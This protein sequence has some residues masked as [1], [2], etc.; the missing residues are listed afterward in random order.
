MISVIIFLVSLLPILLISFF[1]YASGD[2]LGYGAAVKLVLDSHGSVIEIFK[3]VNSTIQGTW[4][5]WQG[6][7]SSIFLFC[8][9]PSI[10][11]E[12]WYTAVPWI[13]LL[14]LCG[15]T[16]YCLHFFLV[17]LCRIRSESFYIIYSFLMIFTIQYM[18]YMRGG[19]FWY[20]SVSH[21]VIPYGAAL[22]CIVWA[23]KYCLKRGKALQYFIPLCLT[24]TYLGGAGYLSIVFALFVI[25]SLQIYFFRQNRIHTALLAVPVTLLLFGFTISAIAPGNSNRGGEGFG[26]HLSD[27]VYTLGKSVLEGSQAVLT[28]FIR[29]RPLFLLI[30][31]LVFAIAEGMDQETLIQI[32][33]ADINSSDLVFPTFQHPILFSVFC[34][35]TSCSVYAP[36]IYANTGVS[37]GVPDTIW[38]VFL[39]LLTIGLSYLVCW[40]RIKRAEKSN[41]TV[42]DIQKLRTVFIAA[43]L[44]FCVLFYRHL[45]G[46]SIDYTCYTFWKS[47]QLE[48]YSVQMKERVDLLA[49]PEKMDVVVPE[50]NEAQGPF[51]CMAIMPDKDAFVNR[52]TARFYGKNSVVSVPRSEFILRQSSSMH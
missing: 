25:I 47:G 17:R 50:M 15:G 12:R 28:S 3:A 31:V 30:P 11:G 18:P 7:W 23:L 8:F 33:E 2:D 29:V 19:I 48:D 6:T 45:V 51:M 40:F 21:Y 13:S 38:F 9:E 44:L 43:A 46:N 34:F 24:M 16:Y 35:L 27:I 4:Y 41:T 26:L 10:W 37:G 32:H 20:T 42:S 36:A 52:A 1:G 14:F 49:D 22:F 39:L 5:S